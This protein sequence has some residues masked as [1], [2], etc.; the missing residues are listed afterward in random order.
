VHHFVDAVDQT[1]EVLPRLWGADKQLD[2]FLVL[3]NV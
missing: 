2:G 3:L 1:L